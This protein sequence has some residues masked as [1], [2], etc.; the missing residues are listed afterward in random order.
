MVRI[1]PAANHRMAAMKSPGRKRVI[2]GKTNLDQDIAG[3]EARAVKEKDCER[4]EDTM[5]QRDRGKAPESEFEGTRRPGPSADAP[6][7]RT[8]RLGKDSD[9]YIVEDVIYQDPPH[10]E[11]STSRSGSPRSARAEN[12]ESGLGSRVFPDPRFR[13]R[14]A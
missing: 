13:S 3:P 11:G 2:C 7:L 4:S 9:L 8:E 12:L 6:V 1:A 14:V 5:T 10:A